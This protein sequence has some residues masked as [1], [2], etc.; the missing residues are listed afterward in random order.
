M[1]TSDKQRKFVVG[2]SILLFVLVALVSVVGIY[3]TESYDKENA[4]WKVQAQVQDVIDLLLVSPFLLLSALLTFF[5][6]RIG[7]SLWSGVTLYLIYTFSIYCFSIHFNQLF[8]LYCLILGV[9]FYAFAFIVYKQSN[10]HTYF[11]LEDDNLR[12]VIGTYLSAV[13]VCFYAVWLLEIITAQWEGTVPKSLQAVALFTNP[14]HVLD[15]SLVLPGVFMTG[16]LLWKKNQLGLLLAPILLTFF[17]LMDITI[18]VLS[19]AQSGSSSVN[20]GLCIV[21]MVMGVFSAALLFLY[22]KKLRNGGRPTH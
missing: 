8:V 15:L 20:W 14:V 7:L 4:A 13:A 22:F 12:N 16:L 17:V 18:L 3:G 9:S 5:N 21:F 6:R 19:I 2:V 10:E 1:R 11:Y